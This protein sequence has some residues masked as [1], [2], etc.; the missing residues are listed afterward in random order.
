MIG[1]IETL[2]DDL[3]NTWQGPAIRLKAKRERAAFQDPQQFFALCTRKPCGASASAAAAQTPQTT[4]LHLFVPNI[5]GGATN[6]ELGCNPGLREFTCFEQSSAGE[7][8]LF[9]LFA[10]K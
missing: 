10:G 7:A 1:Y 5:Y 8:T 2:C 6:A 3:L 9:H 4:V